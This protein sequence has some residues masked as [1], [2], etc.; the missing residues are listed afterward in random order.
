M[1]LAEL[2]NQY[3]LEKQQ[4]PANVNQL[5]DFLQ[6]CYILNELTIDQYRRMLRKLSVRGAEKP[7]YF[8]SGLD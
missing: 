6:R 2:M 1:T 5:L 8:L 4:K 3:V 7:E